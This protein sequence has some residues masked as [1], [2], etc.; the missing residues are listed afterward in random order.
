MTC[1]TVHPVERLSPRQA[2]VGAVSARFAAYI[3][4]VGSAALHW[5]YT[6]QLPV[7]YGRRSESW[8]VGSVWTGIGS[9]TGAAI[10]KLLGKRLVFCGNHPAS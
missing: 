6:G 4:E 7:S 5:V 3:V 8:L 2:G 10:G 9:Q 1:S